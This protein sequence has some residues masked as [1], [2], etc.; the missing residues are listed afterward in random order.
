[1]D[2][3]IGEFI[4]ILRVE[5]KLSQGDLA[6][7]LNVTRQTV[8]KWET[9]V[10]LPSLDNIKEMS[11]IF[12]VEI[13]ELINGELKLVDDIEKNSTKKSNMFFWILFLFILVFWFFLLIY[14]INNYNSVSLYKIRGANDNFIL[15]DSLLFISKEKIVFKIGN[16]EVNEEVVDSSKDFKIEFF[17]KKGNKTSSVETYYFESDGLIEEFYGYNEIFSSTFLESLQ[18]MML[19][20][21]YFDVEGKIQSEKME[22]DV[23]KVFKNSKL[24]YI[25]PK[26]S[27]QDN[28]SSV[29]IESRNK[30]L[31]K[32]LQDEG[33]LFCSVDNICGVDDKYKLFYE[34]TDG[35]TYV[36]LGRVIKLF[37]FYEDGNY[38]FSDNQINI[39]SIFFSGKYILKKGEFDGKFVDKIS[40]TQKQLL[41]E[42]VLSLKKIA[43]VL[44][45]YDVA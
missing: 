11:K 29:D 10:S 7:L 36:E 19:R 44:G 4:K 37:S 14:F 1:M 25:S 32:K 31:K 34:Y 21:E 15:N 38:F 5:K 17:V 43:K 8:S 3:K 2:N 45:L 13:E 12:E 6:E 33:F 9:G 24:L 28:K 42:H 26:S 18:F 22:L 27:N 20:V 30:E 40:K 41:K 35:V 16:I 23:S 39:D